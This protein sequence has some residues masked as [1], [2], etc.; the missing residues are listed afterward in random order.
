MR[1]PGMR[2]QP[3]PEKNPVYPVHRCESKICPCSTLNRFP[4]NRGHGMKPPRERG[5]C[6]RA[7][8]VSMWQ[9]RPASCP[10][11]VLRVSSW[12][13]FLAFVVHLRLFQVN[14]ERAILPRAAPSA[15]PLRESRPPRLVA[16]PIPERFPPGRVPAGVRLP[17]H[18]RC[19][20][21]PGSPPERDSCEPGS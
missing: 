14:S 11:V 20:R 4:A 16:G 12:I 1:I 19:S 13:S 9:S 15:Q 2:S 3:F 8:A 18:T 7:T 10:F 21:L 5:P 6:C 17:P